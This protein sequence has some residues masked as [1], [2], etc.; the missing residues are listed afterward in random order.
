MAIDINLG[1][2]FIWVSNMRH[3]TLL[4]FA[5]EVGASIARQ[6]DERAFVE[7]LRQ[8]SEGPDAGLTFDLEE[9]FP[10]IDEKKFWARVYHLVA[11]RIYLRQLGNQD[12]QR[13]QPSA[14]G[15][16]YVVARMLT[17]A[18]QEIELAWHPAL[19]DP[20]DAEPAGI[21]VRV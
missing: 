18:V 15:D 7:R 21:R 13:W 14:I 12:D 5:I 10:A 20:G 9:R 2:Q 3:L 8:F 1:D 16:A 4:E 6:E 19:D 11:R 17:R